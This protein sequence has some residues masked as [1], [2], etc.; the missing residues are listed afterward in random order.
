MVRAGSEAYYSS[1]AENPK[2]K[3]NGLYKHYMQYCG[4]VSKS[5]LDIFS[6]ENSNIYTK[7]RLIAEHFG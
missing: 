2:Q 3:S 7:Q 6:N 1:N 5:K 4:Q